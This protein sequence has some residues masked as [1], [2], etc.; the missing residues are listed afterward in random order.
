MDREH[1]RRLTDH[2]DGVGN[3]SRGEAEAAGAEL[4]AV[5]AHDDDDLTGEHKEG[6]V[7]VRVTVQGGDLS[8]VEAVFEGEE[9][10]AGL[11]GARLPGV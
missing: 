7:L 4:A 9:H 8:A 2:G 3:S 1:T 11:V 5:V 6:F 10:A